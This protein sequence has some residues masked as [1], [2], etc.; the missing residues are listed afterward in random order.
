MDRDEYEQEKYLLQIE[1]LKRAV[2]EPGQRRPPHHPCSRD[3]TPRARAARSSGSP[4]TSIPRA[5]TVVALTK[6]TTREQGQWY[7]QR[8]VQHF[9]TSGENGAVRPVLVQPGGASST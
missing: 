8:Y 6:P 5:A 1:L 3:A 7:F 2:L 4:N 9:P